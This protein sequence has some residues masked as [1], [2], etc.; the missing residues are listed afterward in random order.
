MA[1][2]NQQI[3][4]VARPQGSPKLADFK[5]TSAPTA[6][7]G[8]DEGLVRTIYLSLDP[9]MRGRMSEAKSYVS[10][11]GIGDVMPGG[12][13]GQVV[14]SNTTDL[15]EGDFVEG[16][17]GWQTHP[18]VKANHLRKIEPSPAPISTAVGVLGMP[19]LTAYFGLLEVASAKAGD[20]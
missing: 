13:V 7:P 18:T 12:V 3:C 16:Y 9:Y 19:G 11:T 6:D 5:V 1:T 15:A 10:A 2:Q 17:L 14:V 4:L 8:E 20:S